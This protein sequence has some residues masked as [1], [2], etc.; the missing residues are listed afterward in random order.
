MA[1]QY[2]RAETHPPPPPVNQTEVSPDLLHDQPRAVVLEFLEYLFQA[3]IVLN[4]AYLHMYPTPS[5]HPPCT[6]VPHQQ[7]PE[8]LAAMTGQGERMAFVGMLLR[9]AQRIHCLKQ[10]SIQCKHD[11][12]SMMAELKHQRPIIAHSVAVLNFLTAGLCRNDKETLVSLLHLVQAL[13]ESGKACRCYHPPVQLHDYFTEGSSN[14]TLRLIDALLEQCPRCADTKCVKEVKAALDQL[15]WHGCGDCESLLVDVLVYI[16]MLFRTQRRMMASLRISLEYVID[17]SQVDNKER[18]FVQLDQVLGRTGRRLFNSGLTE[19]TLPTQDH[20]SPILDYFTF[21]IPM[22][23]EVMFISGW[24]EEKKDD[25]YY[26]LLE[27]F[28]QRKEKRPFFI[29]CKHQLLQH[30]KRRKCCE[31]QMREYLEK[32]INELENARHELVKL[33][34]SELNV[35]VCIIME[36]DVCTKCKVRHIPAI[37]SHLNQY[38]IPLQLVA[39]LPYLSNNTAFLERLTEVS[40]PVQQKKYLQPFEERNACMVRGR[41]RHVRC[42]EQCL[43]SK[44]SEV[45]AL[46]DKKLHRNK[47]HTC[48]SKV[49]GRKQHHTEIDIKRTKMKKKAKHH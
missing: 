19:V 22:D 6:H 27:G 43:Y 9:T 17:L 13:R 34:P 48:T 23:Y 16:N 25:M 7:G 36:E 14:C 26:L 29:Q 20:V 31:P 30:D 33:C 12:A 4:D 3:L 11:F 18:M 47:S 10:R 1:Y 21:R 38:G 32:V 46:D 40:G 45:L 35:K 44:P 37:K 49:E 5:P 15:H 24:Q 39:M 42:H 2:V 28:L 41:C 8:H